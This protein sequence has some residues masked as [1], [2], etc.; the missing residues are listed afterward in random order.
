[1]RRTSLRFMTS[2]AMTAVLGAATAVAEPGVVTANTNIRS[3]PGTSYGQLGQLPAGT[4]VEIV[5]CSGNW[6][7]TSLGYVSARLVSRT[8]PPSA[9]GRASPASAT[10]APASA[11]A[12]P[13]GSTAI[14]PATDPV[15]AA[16][17]NVHPGQTDT[18]SGTRTTIG[19]VNVRSGP[20]TEFD[21]VNTLP[22]AT[23]VEVRSC[24][25]AWCRIEEGY[26]SLYVLSRGPVRQV[27]S[28]DAQPRIPVSVPPNSTTDTR[29]G[30]AVT[31]TTAEL[32][33]GPG[34]G[35]SLLGTLPAGFPVEMGS[36]D[37]G[38][39]R[40][41][42]G[43]VGARLLRPLVTPA[44][45]PSV[46]VTANPGPASDTAAAANIHPG[47]TDTMSGTRTTIGAVNVRSGPGTEF[48]V[49]KTLPDAT[50]VEVQSC[51]KAWC[52][53]EGGYVSL[54]VLSR[55]PVRQ[56]L[57]P[58][59]QP[60]PAVLP[61]DVPAAGPTTP[62]AGGTQ[63]GN[64]TTTADANVR[65]GPG[66]RYSTLGTLAAGSQVTVES[67]AGNWC[68]TQYGYVN[69]RLLSRGMGARQPASPSTGP[70]GRSAAPGLGWQANP[71]LG[72]WGPGYN[73][74][75]LPSSWGARP[76]YWGGRPTYWNMAPG[77]QMA[78]IDRTT[79]PRRSRAAGYPGPQRGQGPYELA[80]FTARPLL[81]QPASGLR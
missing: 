45:S 69:A 58:D 71:Q 41:Q 62:D 77:F 8:V 61:P 28:P 56:V 76:S 18:M 50:S 36:C 15:N 25:N 47:Q 64:A 24:A 81:W 67:C 23:S 79:S 42:Y 16:A 66:V 12:L 46:P 53:V 65:S 40:T 72:Y 19:T 68:R 52:R 2:M 80:T 38:W 9:G 30:R 3:G 33:S 60:R 31:T 14:N 21:V 22:D 70:K 1:M 4:A 57:S 51:A 49:V 59:A 55:G 63:T 32:R 73:G 27:L 48:D 29:T 39:C 75:N 20:G 11:L 78:G 54:Y 44:V 26:V 35:S 74:P 7:R 37:G 13:A 6:C 43:Y 17:R 5:G 34:L 10:G